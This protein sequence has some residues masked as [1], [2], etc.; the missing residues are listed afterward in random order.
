MSQFTP[1]SYIVES[2]GSDMDKLRIDP[3][4]SVE[5][6]AT[7][8]NDLVTSMSTI[9]LHKEPIPKYLLPNEAVLVNQ[10]PQGTSAVDMHEYIVLDTT[11]DYKAWVEQFRRATE[12]TFLLRSNKQSNSA[13]NRLEYVCDRSDTNTRQA[14]M[15]PSVKARPRQKPSKKVGCEARI[16]IRISANEGATFIKIRCHTAHTIRAAAEISKMRLSRE[17]R[18]EVADCI[19]EG[20]DTKGVRD[21]SKKRQKDLWTFLQEN[22]GFHSRCKGSGTT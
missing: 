2:L 13:D 10:E 8:I 14:G 4:A 3:Q 22:G 16:F 9:K 18:N 20:L 11:R 17:I 15:N 5:P 1:L 6:L 7:V 21:I 19:I 12:A